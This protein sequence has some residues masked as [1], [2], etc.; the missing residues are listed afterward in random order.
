MKNTASFVNRA[1]GAIFTT[2]HF[3]AKFTNWPNKL[4]AGEACQGKT[5]K[6]SCPF[7]SYK[8]NKVL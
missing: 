6:L 3:F 7:V 8:E 5:L 2:L 1:P 4:E